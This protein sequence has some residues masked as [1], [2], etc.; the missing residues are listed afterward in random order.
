MKIKHELIVTSLL[1]LA[2]S[3]PVQAAGVTL[4]EQNFDNHTGFPDALKSTHAENWGVHWEDSN[5][6]VQAGLVNKVVGHIGNGLSGIYDGTDKYANNEKSIYT[7]QFDLSE[8]NDDNMFKLSFKYDAEIYENNSWNH[9]DGFSVAAYT[10]TLQNT[11][12]GSSITDLQLLTPA[13]GMNYVAVNNSAGS[14]LNSLNGSDQGFQD[15]GQSGTAMFDLAGLG[16][17]GQSQVNIRF[18]FAS[19]A[20]SVNEGINIDKIRITGTCATSA[21]G[22]GS[23]S[24]CNPPD[25][26]PSGGQIP[27]PGTLALSILGLAAI[28][29]RRHAAIAA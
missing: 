3:G 21:A 15:F 9:G 7:V 5:T 22:D 16:L 12:D 8:V 20:S 18:A 1:I 27:E 25:D 24:G 19:G 14:S 6:E 2:A 11:F 28:Y 29:R 26:P 10:G 23:F 17:A 4:W 13:S